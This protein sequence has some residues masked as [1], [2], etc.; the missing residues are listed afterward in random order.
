MTTGGGDMKGRDYWGKGCAEHA[1]SL[2]NSQEIVLLI[3]IFHQTSPETNDRQGF[4]HKYR[5]LLHRV[6]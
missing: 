5:S 6:H 4:L 3:T 1:A 2:K